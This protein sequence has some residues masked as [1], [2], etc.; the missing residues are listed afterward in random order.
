M[1]MQ[2]R[3]L[4]SLSGLRIQY[5]HKLRYRSQMWVFA[6]YSIA[7]AVADQQP[8]LQFDPQPGNFYTQVWPERKNERKKKERGK[9]TKEMKL[10]SL[11]KSLLV[12]ESERILLILNINQ[13]Y[14]KGS[15]LW[16][17]L[18]FFFFFFFF[19]LPCFFFPKE[20]VRMHVSKK[21]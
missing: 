9:K 14:Q 4:A 5:C 17:V 10:R 12:S 13:S 7:V 8:Q 3:S 1:S 2:V 18:F 11:V 21:S 19:L 20:P 15:S 16:T 6:G